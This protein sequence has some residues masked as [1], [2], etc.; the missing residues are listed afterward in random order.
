MVGVLRVLAWLLEIVGAV[1][2]GLAAFGT[3]IYDS[4]WLTRARWGSNDL[5]LGALGYN[6]NGQDSDTSVGYTLP[7][8]GNGLLYNV[9]HGVSYVFVLLPIGFALAVLAVL[10]LLCGLT[11]APAP[12]NVSLVFAFL[13]AACAAV[14]FGFIFVLKDDI[15]AALD[16][17]A[18]LDLTLGS[19]CYLSVL[20]AIALAAAWV[21]LV[22]AACC[23]GWTPPARRSRFSRKASGTD[24]TPYE[25]IGM[26]PASSYGAP[27]RTT[28]GGQDLPQFVEYQ[29]VP[30]PS[31]PGASDGAGTSLDDSTY[32]PVKTSP[33]EVGYGAAP[34]AARRPGPP[35]L[36]PNAHVETQQASVAPSITGA[37][38]GAMPALGRPARPAS[39]GL[40]SEFA[41]TALPP[42]RAPLTTTPATVVHM[43]PPVP[44]RAPELA[45]EAAPSVPSMPSVPPALP[46]TLA[47]SAPPAPLRPAAQ[48]VTTTM[49]DPL[50][51]TAPNAPQHERETTAHE[52]PLP[53]V[54]AAPAE[55]PRASSPASEHTSVTMSPTQREIWYLP[56][57]APTEAPPPYVEHTE[58][59]LAA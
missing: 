30:R 28:G 57:E 49:L 7:G 22:F 18:G 14:G 53:A 43:P 25:P 58:T 15:S 19:G 36:T 3:P 8:G 55:T 37:M 56:D 12:R 46:A 27:P 1:L 5:K 4:V 48:A 11:G 54:P 34:L 42:R 20:G 13:G 10:F 6:F 41:D 45:P 31:T 59:P 51:W 32:T 26:T 35:P 50:A 33:Y 44:A 2:V 29:R 40:D 16:S 9:A 17:R 39:S 38:P 21:L 23:S 24:R 47:A 52:R